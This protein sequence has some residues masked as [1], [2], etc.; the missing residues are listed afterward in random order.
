LRKPDDRSIPE[1]VQNI[2]GKIP[3]RP[4]QPEADPA[5]VAQKKWASHARSIGIP[6][7]LHTASF[8]SSKQTKLIEFSQTYSEGPVK[9]GRCLVLAGPTGVGKSW[10]AACILRA[11][12]IRWKM[13]AYY[14]ATAG[15]L[16]DPER[17]AV[18]L[19]SLKDSDLLIL[20]DFGSEYQKEGGLVE[21]FIDEIIWHREG[22]S[23]ATV[24]TTNLTFEKLRVRLSDRIVDRLRGD[25]G[26]VYQSPGDSLRTGGHVGRK[27]KT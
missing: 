14:P 11:V 23:L 3:A 5:E 27:L 8:E 17:R 19:S 24:L 6:K 7:K 20:D 21:A 4:T 2:V 15:A 13:Y 1:I 26:M 9:D 22:E 10:A 18:T 25:W 16:L 12:K